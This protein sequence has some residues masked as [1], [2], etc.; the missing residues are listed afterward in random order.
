MSN[1]RI[2]QLDG[3]RG[4][5]ILSVVIAHYFGEVPHGIRPLTAGWL[6]VELFFVLSGFLIGGIL[7]D[8]RNS[9]QYF[10][11]F[12]IRRAF[13]IVPI[14]YTVLAVV[15]I[16][17]AA[18]RGVHAGWVP[19]SMSPAV[20]FTYTQNIAMAASGKLDGFWFLPTWTLAVEEQFYL[21]L[22]LLV[23]LVPRRYIAGLSL[24]A[25]VSAPVLRW[26]VLGA[27]HANPTAVYSLLP[28]RWDALFFGVLAA[29]VV[30]EREWFAELRR[31]GALQWAALVGA[32]GILLCAIADKLYGLQLFDVLGYS[33]AAL[34]FAGIVLMSVAGLPIGRRFEN[35]LLGNV[36]RIS[37]GLYLM[38]QPVL[39]ILHGALRGALPDNGTLAGLSITLLALI[40]SLAVAWASWTFFESRLVQFGHR[41]K[42][43]RRTIGDIAAEA[44]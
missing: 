11:T 8:N 42:Y 37:Y 40:V 9:A 31:R 5:A 26:L 38:H 27:S 34:C 14:Y 43:D 15:L 16:A 23:F 32:W 4:I 18:L 10:S 12:Y 29:Y 6:G 13:R 35:R 28:C 30:R 17:S 24:F 3:L 1:R 22:P 25:I 36:G 44:A 7:L 21:L 19:A 33:F 41:W 39:G 2:P 20:Y